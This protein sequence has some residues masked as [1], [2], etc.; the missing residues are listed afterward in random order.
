MVITL[1]LLHSY[2]GFIDKEPEVQ[3]ISNFDLAKVKRLASG[4][5]RI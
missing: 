5:S 2:P 1:I 3:R 4:R